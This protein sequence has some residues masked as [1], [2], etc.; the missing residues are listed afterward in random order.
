MVPSIQETDDYLKMKL[1]DDWKETT[2]SRQLIGLENEG[3]VVQTDEGYRVT[4]DEKAKIANI[5]EQFGRKAEVML[6]DFF[7]VEDKSCVNL[8]L[9][10]R[11]YLG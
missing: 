7:T 6:F 2:L 4:E 10:R 11:I 1:R 3:L 5:E 8:Y 9:C